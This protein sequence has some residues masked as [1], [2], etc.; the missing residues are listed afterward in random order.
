VGEQERRW[1]SVAEFSRYLGVSDDVV[2]RLVKS[3]PDVQRVTRKLGGRLMVCLWAYQ[4]S[5]EAKMA[6]GAP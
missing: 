1:V 4:Q 5:V 3:D 6:E 2:Y